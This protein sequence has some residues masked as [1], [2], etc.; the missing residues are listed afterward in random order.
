[1]S[2][3]VPGQ[4]LYQ[5]R[6]WAIQLAKKSNID[7]GEVDWFL[8]GLSQLTGL[9]L[10]LGDYQNQPGVL[11]SVPLRELTER[12]QRRIDQNVP[13]QYLVGETPWR[14]FLLTVT[15][16]VLIPRPETEL[17]IDIAAELVA[18]RP[19]AKQEHVG[20]WA[21]LGTGSGAIA[22]GLAYTLP[23]ARVHAV[24]IS[25]AAVKIARLNAE[26]HSLA[27]R[28]TFFQGSWLSPLGHLQGQLTGIVSNPPY[29]PSQLV[30]TLQP[31]VA[32]HEPHLAL[33]GGLDGLS[34][35]R[36]LISEGATYL[37]PGGLWLTELMMGQ[38]T[39]VADLLSQ[40]GAYTDV[41]IHQDLSGIDR[42]VS[43]RKAL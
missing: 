35:I 1:M 40:Q 7:L 32:N 4:A 33:D 15:P 8:Q 27:H 42:F 43:A 13:V 25:D 2:T 19:N 39:T 9:S 23:N 36:H 11:L 3:A 37:Q 41:T 14:N 20:N 29:I 22:L 17:M 16:D 26:K 6:Q 24:D 31:E 5:W 18:N 30:L 38:A 28:I 10:Q 34:C 12:W 21:D